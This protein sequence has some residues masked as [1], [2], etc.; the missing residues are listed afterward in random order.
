MDATTPTAE[1]FSYY[2][3]PV[4]SGNDKIYHRRVASGEAPKDFKPFRCDVMGHAANGAIIKVGEITFDAA[5]IPQAFEAL[6]E[7]LR[8]FQGQVQGAARKAMLQQSVNAA[9]HLSAQQLAGK[10]PINGV[11][12]GLRIAT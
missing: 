10:A 2:E 12:K 7:L 3:L 11:G 5:D 4:I 6:P 1:R 9:A 8:G